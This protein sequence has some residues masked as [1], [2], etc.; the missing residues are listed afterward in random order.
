MDDFQDESFQKKLR[1]IEQNKPIKVKDKSKDKWIRHLNKQIEALRERISY[2]EALN[3]SLRRENSLLTSS[4]DFYQ[5]QLMDKRFPM[6]IDFS[7]IEEEDD[8]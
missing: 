7:D 3:N 5:C 1:K 8:L 2:L 4:V 6:R